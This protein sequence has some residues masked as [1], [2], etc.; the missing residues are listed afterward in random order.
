MKIAIDVRSLMEG[1]H[2]GVEEY[3]V[4]IIRALIR[5]APQHSY[6]LFYNSYKDVRLPDFGK[7]RVITHG[8]R[9]PNKIFNVWQLVTGHP[10]W[11]NLIDQHVDVIFVP[12]VRLTPLSADVPLVAVMHDLSYE[13]FPEF[14]NAWR[15]VW[16]RMM[17]PRLMMENADHV[18]SDSEHTKQDLIHLYK[19]PEAKISVVYPGAPT[20]PVPRAADIHA[21]RRRYVLPDKFVLSF[22]S[23]EPRKN[24]ASII[25]AWSAI[26]SRV[27]HDLVIAGDKGWRQ[28]EI[29]KVIQS[30]SF[31]KRIHQI[32]FVAEEEKLAVYAAADLFVYPSF[33]EGFG[34]PP[35]E[36]LLAGTPVITSFNSALPEVVGKW[37]TLIDPYNPSQ[38]AAV[39][40]EMLQRPERVL[41]ET[42]KEISRIFS[43]D[44]AARQIVRILE[45][46]S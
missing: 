11:D 5:V 22:G 17:R 44:G 41:A 15:R 37:A 30:S 23:I 42:K 8:F 31:K 18:I 35:L 34:F 28:N 27:P 3:T 21:V 25:R 6:H 36:S 1:R 12:S 10:H 46:A 43:W 29:E 20:L 9:F 24:V 39:M 40:Q 38:L 7:G 2:S 45:K 14:L 19:L 26:A 32:G 16:H 13:R 33:Y 4:Q